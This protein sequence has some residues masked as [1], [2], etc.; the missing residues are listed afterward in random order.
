MSLPFS[1][2]R[3]YDSHVH[4]L[5]TGELA[6]QVR[7]DDLVD[8]SAALAQAPRRGDWR[9]LFGWNSDVAEFRDLRATALDR[10]DGAKPLL[11]SHRSGHASVINSA[12]LDA[13][14]WRDLN[15]LPAELRPFATAAE[16]GRLTGCFREQAHFFI[17]EK[18]PELTP[19]T[20]RQYLLRAQEIFL[21]AGF[22]HIREMMGDAELIEDVLRLEGLK[23]LRLY[24]EMLLHVPHRQGLATALETARAFRL[25]KSARLR[26]EGVKLFL[27]GALG[28]DTA[29]LAAPY[30]HKHDHHG[31]LLWSDTDLTH[32]LRTAWGEG[33]KVAVHTIGDA[34]MNQVLQIAQTLKTEGI[35]GALCLEHAEL[36]APEAFK[37]M[38]GLAL[39]FHFQPSH[40]LDDAAMLSQKLGDRA[41][42]VFPWHRIEN[43]GF[44]IYFGSDTPIAS[45]SLQRTVAGLRA[46]QVAGIPRL[47]LDWKFAHS[48]PDRHFGKGCRTT[49]A[50]DGRV[51][52][53]EVDGKVDQRLKP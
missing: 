26:V 33:L 53:L 21:D 31:A 52:R 32:A 10:W 29:A 40:Y 35:E 47:E 46:A 18:L 14:G 50:D 4:W 11:V 3:C 36:I 38:R 2:E 19:E 22:T 49:V 37:K 44:P 13:L 17:L 45:P 9:L 25:K 34:A 24:V 48:H 5:P 27:D 43:M 1:I 20:R 23:Q 42:L 30:A 7:V 39:E 6:A 15:D 16:D 8:W 28:A 41:A 12:A 51:L